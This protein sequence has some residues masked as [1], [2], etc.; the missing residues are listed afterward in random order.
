[1]LCLVTV[2]LQK[3]FSIGKTKCGYYINFGIVPYFKDL[4]LEELKSSKYIV[5]SYDENLNTILEEEQ[6][7]ILVIYRERFF[8]ETTEL[9]ET[10][11]FDS[12]FPKRPNSTNLLQKLVESLSSLSH[13]N[14]LQLSMDGP[15][16]N[17]DV[18]KQ[19]H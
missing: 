7:D 11:C 4:L 19:Y 3:K 1:M 14:V 2:T 17:L 12:T 9:G 18:L 10:R 5:V 15:N 13:S 16:S 6:I 8:N